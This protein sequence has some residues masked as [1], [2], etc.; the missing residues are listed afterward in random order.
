MVEALRLLSVSFPG[1]SAFGANGF[2]YSTEVAY[3]L[4][5][6]NGVVGPL[7]RAP[8]I[9]IVPKTK[10][11]RV[12][13]MYVRL[14]WLSNDGTRKTVYAN[15]FTDS[16]LPRPFG[17]KGYDIPDSSVSES[18]RLFDRHRQTPRLEGHV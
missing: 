14:G 11:S 6:S 4:L 2:E 7:E 9:K 12:G 17:A 8:L 16:I 18:L 1:H 3:V 10:A 5:E 15:A 13:W